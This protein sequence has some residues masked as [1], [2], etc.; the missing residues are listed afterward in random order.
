MVPCREQAGKCLRR[1]DDTRIHLRID[2]LAPHPSEGRA[3]FLD[4][5]FEIDTMLSL[6]SGY[7]ARGGSFQLQGIAKS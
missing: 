5:R 4:G 1:V 7:K 3:R 6:V 2:F